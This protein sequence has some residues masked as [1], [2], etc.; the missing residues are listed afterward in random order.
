MCNKEKFWP[1]LCNVL[2]HPE[3]IDDPRLSNFS[4][5]LANREL[6]TQLLDDAL[7]TRKTEDWIE[8]LSGTV[9][10]APVC[11]VAQAL[12]NPF[13]AERGAI[14]EFNGADGRKARLIACPV[15][16]PGIDLPRAAAP[17]MGEHNEEL[18]RGIGLSEAEVQDLRRD[19]VISGTD[20]SPPQVAAATD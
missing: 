8:L 6:V 4:A 12:D 5:R 1:L 13:A 18:L 20:D 10:V 19:G 2:S 17:S 9:P 15:R 11:D 14:A 7:M 3:W 16:I